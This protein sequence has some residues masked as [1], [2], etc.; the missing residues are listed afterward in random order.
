M[1]KVIIAKPDCGCAII[2]A[3]MKP[4]DEILTKDFEEAL[5]KAYPD[6]EDGT[7][8][9]ALPSRRP[10]LADYQCNAAMGLAKVLRTAPAKIAEAIKAALPDN[11][12]IGKAEVHPPGFIN[13]RLSDAWLVKQLE[14]LEKDQ[15]L[16]IDLV[17]GSP[18]V[19]V[20]Y[21]SPNVSKELHVGHIRSTLLGNVIDRLYRFLGYHVIADSHLGD[22]GTQFGILIW[23]Y[24]RYGDE[25]RLEER[26]LAELESLYKR[27]NHECDENP[28]F[29]E[30]ARRE[31]LKLHEGD[32][33][34]YALWKRFVD[35]SRKS[36]VEIYRR[37][38]V[39]FDT[40][41]GESAYHAMLPDIVGLLHDKGI[42]RESDGAEVVFF[43]DNATLSGNP[44]IVRKRDGAF[45]YM[46]T[47]VA[48]LK[49]REDE[50]SPELIVYVTD[51]RQQLHFQQL[52]EIAKRL[53]WK[54]ELAHVWFGTILGDDG[55]PFKT[56]TGEPPRLM[57][58]LDE[59]QKRA[60]DVI[61][62]AGAD[63][64][65]EEEEEVAR[66][67]GVGALKY[68]DLAQNRTS[69]YVFSY[70]RMLALD[71]NTAPYIQYS[72]ARTKS[73]LRKYEER[74]DPLPEGAPILIPEPAERDLAFLLARFPEVIRESA[75]TFYPHVLTDY[76]Y[77]LATTLN[78]KF[79]HSVPVLQSESPVR[80]SRLA[81]CALVARTLQCGLGLLGI[82]VPERM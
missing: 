13:I 3:A 48:T 17:E 14:A 77:S 69:D 9:S 16:G 57:D 46:T 60:H 58:L 38:G 65:P 10:E 42:S 7:T 2:R 52:F 81:L 30:E 21:S 40:I 43:D 54:T 82:E 56:R 79:Y 33:E 35:L 68:M 62:Q 71:G 44:A 51:S 11:P 74:F 50:Y 47:D 76:L 36:I 6:L 39:E 72:Y 28:E 24:R 61:K 66:K 20:D 25:K 8:V 26:G 4:I 53:G 22:W 27:G 1:S 29:R 34:N 64:P 55:R 23:A 15:R 19:V 31:L 78:K 75:R 73:I 32:T 18:T 45:N 59:A 67:V 41:R 63:L 49:H 37:L 5:K 70:D 80:E 12:I